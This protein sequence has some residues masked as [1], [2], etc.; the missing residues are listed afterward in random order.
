MGMEFIDLKLDKTAFSIASLTDRSDD[1]E[2]WHKKTPIER[3]RQIE[4]SSKDKLW[5]S[6]Y[7]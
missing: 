6:S 7:R 4:I 5:T 3:L 2:Y 1:K